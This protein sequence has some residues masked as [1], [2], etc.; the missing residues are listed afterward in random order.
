MRWTVHVSAPN[1]HREL[2]HRVDRLCLESA[3]DEQ[4]H[5]RGGGGRRDHHLAIAAR[6]RSEADRVVLD[7]ML[8]GFDGIDVPVRLCE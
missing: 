8:P 2:T 6:V 1:L 4:V 5:D 3:P 7:W